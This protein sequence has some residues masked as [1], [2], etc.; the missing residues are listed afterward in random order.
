MKTGKKFDVKKF[1]QYIPEDYNGTMETDIKVYEVPKKLKR[2]RKETSI[3]TRIDSN[4][5][6]NETQIRKFKK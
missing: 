6:R 1:Q 4:L 2:D 5:I 3:K